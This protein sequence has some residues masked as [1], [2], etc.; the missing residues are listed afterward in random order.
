MTLQ[1]DLA[2]LDEL[3][4]IVARLHAIRAAAMAL[5]EIDYAGGDVLVGEIDNALEALDGAPG[6]L[7][8][9]AGIKHAAGDKARFDAWEAGLAGRINLRELP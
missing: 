4:A 7:L 9:L 2:T 1:A 8:Y 5:D 6:A 3:P